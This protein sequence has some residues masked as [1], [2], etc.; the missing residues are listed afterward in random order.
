MA[1]GLQSQSTTLPCIYKILNKLLY[2]L[3]PSLENS[4][5][6]VYV[7]LVACRTLTDSTMHHGH[8][9]YEQC[10]KMDAPQTGPLFECLHGGSSSNAMYY[11]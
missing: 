4:I 3:I 2:R 7:P 1:K 9:S 5:D 6:L 11:K 8:L 10:D